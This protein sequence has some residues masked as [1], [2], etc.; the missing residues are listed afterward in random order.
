MSRST[1]AR[2][3]KSIAA[4]GNGSES[5]NNPTQE[6]EKCIVVDTSV[7]VHDPEC[8]DVLPREEG[9]RVFVPRIVLGELDGLKNRPNIGWDV[10]EVTRKIEDDQ[11]NGRSIVIEPRPSKKFSK[12]LRDGGQSSLKPDLEIIAT[13]LKLKAESKAVVLY[14]RDTIHRVL[15]REAGIVAEDYVYGQVNAAFDPTMK[16][17]NVP[18]E[19]HSRWVEFDWNSPETEK[20]YFNEG[21][22]CLSRDPCGNWAELF[23]AL[24]K[25]N[26]SFV[27]VPDD[28]NL[29]GIKP[30]I[31]ENGSDQE[32]KNNGSGKGTKTNWN[33]LAAM[34]QLLDPRINAVFLQGG[35]GTGKTV[36]ALAAALQ[37]RKNYTQIIIA[38]PMVHL[39]DRDE[40]GFLPGGI[41][42][43]MAP[44]MEP[45]LQAFSFIGRAKPENENMIKR[46]QENK[47]IIIKPLDY[48]RGE[49]YHKCFMIIDEAQ[50]LTPHQVKTIITRVGLKTK[51]VFTGDLGQIDRD[52][53]LDRKSSGLAYAMVKLAN[54]PMIGAVNF[55]EGVRSPLASLAEKLL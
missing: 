41:E 32:E 37:Q 55:K 30:F 23:C 18:E 24:Y 17:V 9:G 48:I 51:I 2:R 50:N 6:R 11:Q 13:A 12:G 35:A 14:S 25:G 49:T 39:E 53:R 28:I 54:D 38:R 45:I 15:A 46:L 3:G 21:V 43:K 27:K 42:E 29:V 31:M 44:W 4:Q 36:L 8:F 7:L 26:G 20:L 5:I 40:I 10:R 16:R 47:K 19:I 34:Q 52:R 1:A 22:V 33:H